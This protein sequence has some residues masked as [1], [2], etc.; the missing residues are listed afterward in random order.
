MKNH[1]ISTK[2]TL[3]EYFAWDRTTRIFHWLNVLCVLVL[4][5]LGLAI[6]NAKALGVT[7]EGKILL[8]TIHTYFGYVF[9][10]NLVWRIIW[11]FYGN[12]YAQWK[13]VLPFTTGYLTSLRSYLAG[14]HSDHPD[15]YIGHNPVARIMVTIL[16][17]L[18]SFQAVT[19]LVLAGTDLYLPPFG[20]EIKEQV[21]GAGEDHSK[22]A[23]V[24]P[25]SR[26]NTDQA[27]YEKMRAFREPFVTIHEINFF[28]LI[29]A[30][31]IHL[32]GVI[33][34]EIREGN[35]IVSAMITGKKLLKSSPKDI[36]K[37]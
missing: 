32:L 28:V 22:L 27:G 37:P 15:Y 14:I 29:G 36:K 34:T 3:T 19:G 11:G 16:F 26:E 31:F 12:H 21:T 25:G 7:P 9:V 18:L 35:A 2:R 6:I 8:K 30:I 24:K 5:T 33:F 23:G 13:S 10:A 1:A 17:V 4:I 20:H